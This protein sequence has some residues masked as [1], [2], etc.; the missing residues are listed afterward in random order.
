MTFDDDDDDDKGDEVVRSLWLWGILNLVIADWFTTYV[1]NYSR[2][3]L[4]AKR[5]V[6]GRLKLTG[7]DRM[8][9]GKGEVGRDTILGFLGLCGIVCF[10]PFQ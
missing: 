2:I 9:G 7:W 3:S 6:W 4:V 10:F 1:R 5:G 8:R